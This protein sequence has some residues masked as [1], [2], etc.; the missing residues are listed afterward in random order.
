MK[1][2]IWEGVPEG[3]WTIEMHLAK[4]DYDWDAYD[5]QI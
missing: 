2:K 3:E 5:V 4:L 1:K